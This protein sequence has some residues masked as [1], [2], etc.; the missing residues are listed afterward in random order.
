VPHVLG[1]LP[2]GFTLGIALPPNQ[3]KFLPAFLLEVQNVPHAVLSIFLR[4]LLSHY[5]YQILITHLNA[6]HGKRIRVVQIHKY[7]IVTGLLFLRWN[8]MN[9]Q[10]YLGQP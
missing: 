7:H 1:R 6:N 5:Y 9:W 10:E 4:L 2:G 3:Q 8:K